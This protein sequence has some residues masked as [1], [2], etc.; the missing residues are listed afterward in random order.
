MT[1]A[2]MISNS[3]FYACFLRLSVCTSFISLN[4]VNRLIFVTVKCCVFIAVRTERRLQSVVSGILIIS[5]FV[6]A[7]VL[8]HIVLGQRSSFGLSVMQ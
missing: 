1:P 5:C 4:S 2:L 3:A 8:I 6:P 7:L